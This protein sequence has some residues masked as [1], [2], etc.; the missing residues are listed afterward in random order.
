LALAGDAAGID[1]WKAIAVRIQNLQQR[2]ELSQ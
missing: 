2:S 1:T